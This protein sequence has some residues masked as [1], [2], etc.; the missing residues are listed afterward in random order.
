[1]ITTVL[2]GTDAKPGTIDPLGSSLKPG[3]KL[4]N[5]LIS[6]IAVSLAECL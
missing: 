5:K 2:A 6:N 4:D 1:M 3:P